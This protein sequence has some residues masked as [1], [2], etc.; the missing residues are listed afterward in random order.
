MM[1]FNCCFSALV[2]LTLRVLLAFDNRLHLLVQLRLADEDG[3]EIVRAVRPLL[4]SLVLGFVDVPQHFFQRFTIFLIHGKKE[5]RHHHHNHQQRGSAGGDD[6]PQDKEKRQSYED[7]AT[8]THDL[9]L[10]KV[11]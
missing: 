4:G 10:G 5:K 9:A 3:V 7:A 11:K 6:I 2:S 8:E 1:A